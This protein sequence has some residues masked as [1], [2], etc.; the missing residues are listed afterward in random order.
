MPEMCLHTKPELGT[1]LSRSKKIVTCPALQKTDTHKLMPK[2]TRQHNRDNVTLFSDLQM[3]N[4]HVSIF[5]V[6]WL[7]HLHR[8][9]GSNIFSIFLSL[10]LYYVVA[11]SL[12][13]SKKIVTCPALQ[14]TDTHKLM[15]KYKYISK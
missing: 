2:Y 6:A 7:L 15:P 11:L 5:V 9:R 10:K 14:K 8:H 13:R 4:Y 1:R 3:V 12:S